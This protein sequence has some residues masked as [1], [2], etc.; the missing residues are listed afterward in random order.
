M[1]NVT[2]IALL[3]FL[4]QTHAQD[5][6][7]LMDEVAT[8]SSGR[9]ASQGSAD[10]SVD[11][12]FDN[13]SDRALQASHLHHAELDNAM[14]AKPGHLALHG[15]TQ[16]M[17]SEPLQL[18]G[19]A[20]LG[21]PI[22][23]SRP[24]YT[25]PWSPHSGRRAPVTHARKVVK[26]TT[27]EKPKTTEG[28][29]VKK[30]SKKMSDAEKEEERSML[31]QSMLGLNLNDDDAAAEGLEMRLVDVTDND[32]ELP[33][34]YDPASLKSYFSK[35]PLASLQRSFQV[36][37]A[38][39]GFLAKVALDNAQGRT[40]DPQIQLKRAAEL[41][42]LVTSLGPFFI[43]IGQSLSIRPDILP[44]KSMVEL[45]KLCDKVP[46]FDSKV[47]MQTIT[48]ELG[49]NPDELFSELTPKP[50]A[51]AS[52]GQVYKGRLRATGEEVAVKVQRP[53]VLETVSLDLYLMRELGLQLRRLPG[54]LEDRRTDL[55]KLVDEFAGRFYDELDYRIECQNG[56][57]IAEHMKSLPKIVIPKCY[58]K[59]TSRRVLTT[60]W[61]DGEK[62]AQSKAN[63][64]ND[65][66]N[67]G[68]VAYLTQLLG[69]G[70]FHADPHPGNMIRTPD[71]RLCILDFGLMTE[72]TDDQKYGMIEAIV[73]LI[74]RDY[75]EI[76]DDFKKLDFIPEDVDTEPIIP[77]LTN[78]F[79]AALAGGGAKNINF[80][81]LAADLAQQCCH[82][83][84]YFEISYKA[85]RTSWVIQRSFCMHV[86]PVDDYS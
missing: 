79:N 25:F 28:R 19:K 13:L 64:V 7:K 83:F 58:P 30:L 69:E 22:V 50:V 52:L 54:I 23:Q 56:I 18:R 2:M 68:V 10:K 37:S 24:G 77:S 15:P 12:L 65:L 35:R 14:L 45:Q 4:A 9:F 27:L 60:E 46:P 61:V 80:N 66:V 16:S 75:E 74:N 11:K 42:D 84:R 40:G 26:T 73:H 51:A 21:H 78:V 41:R 34:H 38:A 47:A 33:L 6:Q 62:L 29:N 39:S 72:L 36:S 48:E 57:R 70:F 53:F 71:G 82:Q 76:G 81:D 43:K 49:A 31:M 20:M 67:V 55:V 86:G 3:T 17:P 8:T 63:D 85:K 32:N 44:A 59:Y 1:R 5:T